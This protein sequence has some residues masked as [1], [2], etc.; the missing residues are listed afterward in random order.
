MSYPERGGNSS[1]SDEFPRHAE[2]C[3]QGRSVTPHPYFF[4]GQI[5]REYTDKPLLSVFA[6]ENHREAQGPIFF[7]KTR[8]LW[9]SSW[10]FPLLTWTKKHLFRRTMFFSKTC[11]NPEKCPILFRNRVVSLLSR[12]YKNVR[13]CDL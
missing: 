13:F 4:P 3:G 10:I 9:F 8:R 7:A 5:A 6:A 2:A 1:G 11:L 12:D